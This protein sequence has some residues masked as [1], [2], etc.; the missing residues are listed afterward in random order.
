MFGVICVFGRG[1]N[2]VGSFLG[3]IA[4]V[5]GTK[6]LDP[7]RHQFLLKLLPLRPGGCAPASHSGH[8]HGCSTRLRELQQRD[9]GH[10]GRRAVDH[11]GVDRDHH[12]TCVAAW[13]R[14]AHPEGED[15]EGHHLAGGA[16]DTDREVN[17][18]S[19]F[20]VAGHLHQPSRSCTTQVPALARAL[21][22]LSTAQGHISCMMSRLG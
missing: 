7:T 11:R 16:S 9:P 15:R 12:R 14:V 3:V 2:F 8:E 13:V 18:G 17:E 22:G 21:T 5:L 4:T 10:H 6:S 19:C 1:G 20:A